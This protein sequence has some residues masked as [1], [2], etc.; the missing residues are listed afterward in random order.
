MR[1]HWAPYPMCSPPTPQ[2]LP[3]HSDSNQFIACL[4]ESITV[5]LK[6]QQHPSLFYLKTPGMIFNEL[7]SIPWKKEEIHK[8]SVCAPTGHGLCTSIH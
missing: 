1:L 6:H 2:S 5:H 7:A 3:P 4:V 8:N